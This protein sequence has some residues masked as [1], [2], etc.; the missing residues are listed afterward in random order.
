MIKTVG[1]G[2]ALAM[3]LTPSRVDA[4]GGFFCS[5]SPVDQS[6]ERIVFAVD[7]QTQRT[8]MIVQ[9]SYQG[10]DDAFAWLLPVATVPDN[11]AVFPDGAL[12][13]LDAQ[14]GPSFVA[15]ENCRRLAF[16][17]SVEDSGGDEAEEDHDGV[18]IHVQETVGP[19][20]V[21]VLESADAE[22]TFRWLTDNKYRLSPA[23]KPYLQLYTEAGMKFLALKLTAKAT[24]ADIQ[25]FR[26]C[27]LYTS[28]SPRDS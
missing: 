12:T 8:D 5:A 3:L 23:M 6:A 17:T 4:C 18:T 21:V 22:K 11:R 9:I 2:A 24:V 7:E 19:Y 27:L 20:D 15:P 28:P 25:P 10:A 16:P 26:I 13:P 1:L 14:T